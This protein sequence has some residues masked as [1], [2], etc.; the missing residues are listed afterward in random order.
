MNRP[1]I[2]GVCGSFPSH[3]T[4][5]SNTGLA[6]GDPVRPDHSTQSPRTAGLWGWC[7]AQAAQLCVILVCLL[8]SAALA[9]EAGANG[10]GVGPVRTQTIQLSAGWNAVYLEIEPLK[11]DPSELFAG[12]P[13]SIAAAYFRPATSMEF[14]ESPDVALPDRKR[15]NVW[16]APGREDA[17]LSN[18][19]AIQAHHAYLLYAEQPYTWSMQGTPFYGAIQW[20]PNAFNLVG[21]PLDSSEQPTMANF[22]SGI[23]AHNPLKAYRLSNGQWNLITNPAQTLM[24]PGEAFWVYSQGASSYR[25]PLEVSFSSSSLGGLVFSESSGSRQLEIRNVSPFPQDLTLSLQAG[26]NGILP[27]SYMVRILDGPDQPIATTAV[28]F[29]QSLKLG[30][31][32]AGKAFV[33]ELQVAQESVTAAT[34]NTTLSISSNA[35]SRVDVPLVSIRSDLLSTP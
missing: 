30:P 12:T 29:P 18:L 17:L 26:K 3:P 9:A 4:E 16:Y 32:E 22:F 8:P 33:L 14:I 25:G 24:K 1:L 13:V 35:G 19:H 27:L 7:S 11:G 15:W 21:F 28:A 34:M 31:L 20:H 6:D 5:V 10:S 23:S 2:Q